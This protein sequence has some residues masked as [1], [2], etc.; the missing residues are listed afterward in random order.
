MLLLQELLALREA[1]E[2]PVE[3]KD[4]VAAFPKHH[5]KA[6]EKLWGGRRLVWH[7][8]AFFGH[9]EL[10]AAYV[11]AEKAAV[12]Y[13]NDGYETEV[14][15]QVEA[16]DLVQSNLEDDED[17]GGN[18]YSGSADFT[19]MAGFGDQDGGERQ[20]CY[21]GYDPVKDK[22]YIGFDAWVS[23]ENFNSD[24]DKAFEEATGMSYDGDDEEHHAV[25][26][27]VWKEYQSEGYGFW[28]LVFEI[29]HNG[30]EYHAEEAEMPMPG[31]FYRGVFRQFKARHPK[32]IDLRLD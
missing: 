21:L 9:N 17:N 15:Q 2:V 16:D 20:E 14:N 27:K 31:G 29:T 5:G 1:P 10:G 3:L 19:W 22:L 32:V 7:G 23:E 30:D 4:I 28:G 24:F 25:F 26:D 6:L 13:I 11:K 12:A 18:S 8:D